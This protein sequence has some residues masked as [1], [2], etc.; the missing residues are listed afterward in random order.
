MAQVLEKDIQNRQMGKQMLIDRLR[1]S[2]EFLKRIN[3]LLGNDTNPYTQMVN[4]IDRYL[5]KKNVTLDSIK[6][7]KE[8]NRELEN[9]IS[10]IRNKGAELRVLLTDTP[11]DREDQSNIIMTKGEI[12]YANNR[13]REL[14]SCFGLL[15]NAIFDLKYS[16]NSI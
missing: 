13:K 8:E 11:E 3:S 16:I 15:G 6:D 12:R 7:H 1:D 2:E 9:Q 10:N 14:S 4:S 5:S